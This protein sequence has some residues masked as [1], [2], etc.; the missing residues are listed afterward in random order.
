MIRIGAR[1][2]FL[3]LILASPSW[4]GEKLLTTEPYNRYLRAHLKVDGRGNIWTAYY[5]LK[6]RIHIK[7]ISE[8]RDFIVNEEL[9]EGSKRRGLGFDVQGEHIFVAWREKIG[10]TKRIYLRATHDGG[11]T[12]SEPV[13]LDDGSTKAHTRIEVD[14]NTKGEVFVIWYGDTLIGDDRFHIHSVSSNDFGKTFSEP[15]NLTAGYAFSIHPTILVNEDGAY[16]F[17]YSKRQDKAYMIFRK[18]VDGGLTWS[19]PHVI[20]ETGNVTTLELPI[21][22]GNRLHVFWIDNYG[23]VPIIMGASSDD[24]GKTWNTTAFE[25]TRGMRVGLLK[26]AHDSG[27]NIYLVFYARWSTEEKKKVYIIRSEDNGA[28]WEKM[29]PLRHYPFEHTH[30]E[31]PNIIATE[32]GEVVVV[33]VDYRNIRRNIY[34]QYSKDSGRT[35]QDEDIPLEEPGRYNTGFYPFINSLVKLDERYYLLAYRYK[36]DVTLMNAGLLLLDFTL[37]GGRKR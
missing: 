8:G 26:V 6:Y 28:T 22:V 32:G 5:D 34:M 9:K 35:W 37:K 33:W 7:N 18:T 10:D 21:M 12:L 2:F 31:N 3:I 19:E 23:D 36:V 25:D 14:S 15:R 4:A 1:V 17:S 13:L 16:T 20:Q 24:G 11:E 30:A 29:M 27:G